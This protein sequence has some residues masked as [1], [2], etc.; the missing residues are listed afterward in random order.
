MIKGREMR[1]TLSVLAVAAFR[2]AVIAAIVLVPTSLVLLGQSLS[3][4]ALTLVC[5]VL[6]FLFT[7]FEAV[8]EIAIGPLR[9]KLQRRIDEAEVILSK[10]RD[11][12][13]TMSE[14]A[15]STMV[16]S[17]YIS[18]FSFEESDKIRT[19]I[20]GLLDDLGVDA[21]RMRQVQF[22]LTKDLSRD[23]VHAILG[24]HEV[25]AGAST[26]Q[27]EEWKAM[28]RVWPLP[29]VE[30]LKGFLSRVGALDDERRL[31]IEDYEQ[32]IKTDTHRRLDVFLEVRLKPQRLILGR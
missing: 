8:E 31:L 27:I 9:A 30:E 20:I 5:L 28:R 2:V 29:T 16:R 13:A 1:H 4:A 11:V 15:L 26:E 21:E 19:Q 6:A 12:A 17:R 24:G 14:I 23:Y 3:L 7:R 18:G 32:F 22:E 10:L 25:P